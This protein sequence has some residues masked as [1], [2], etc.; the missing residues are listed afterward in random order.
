MNMCQQKPK[1]WLCAHLPQLL[2]GL[3]LLQPALDILS[4]WQNQAGMGNGLT[5]LI[6]FAMLLIVALAGELPHDP[7]LYYALSAATTVKICV[8]DAAQPPLFDWTLAGEDG[9][10]GRMAAALEVLASKRD[11]LLPRKHGN[12]PL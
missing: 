3:I 11:V 10:R 7:A 12:M 8:S 4:F 6:R 5:L 1:Q 9:L 2:L